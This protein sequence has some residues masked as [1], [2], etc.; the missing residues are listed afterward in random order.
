MG[1][2]YSSTDSQNLITSMRTNL[3]LANQ[4]TDRLSSGCDHLIATLE[5]GELKGAAYTAGKGLFTEVIIPAIKK[6]QDAIDDIQAEL[7][8]YEY[9]DS[10][11]AEYGIL[12][13]DNLEQQLELKYEQLS[14]V[15]DQ[16][17]INTK[18]STQ[19]SALF[20]G[21]IGELWSQNL[22]LDELKAQI[23]MGIDD[24]K[25]RIEKLNWFNTD[26]SKYFSDSLTVL[27]L[28]IQGALALS[29]ITMDEHGNYY[30]NG[31][32]MSWLNSMTETVLFT[33]DRG[34]DPK[35]S[36]INDYARDLMLSDEA[37]A[38]YR[39]QLTTLLDGQPATE[40]P[41]IIAAYNQTLLF[42]DQGSLLTIIPIN[43]GAGDGYI[44][45]KNGDYDKVYTAQVNQ[46][47]NA[48]ML[49]NLGDQLGQLLLGLG[50][51]I[52]GIGLGAAS[53]ALGA[54]GLV[55]ALPTGGIVT[56]PI[57]AVAGA[58]LAVSGTLVVGGVATTVDSLIQLR[59][60]N[61]NLQ[62][63]FAK[64]YDERPVSRTFKKG[65]SGRVNGRKVD[66]IR[67]D[68]EWKSG[69]S[70]KIQ[71]QSGSGKRGYDLNIDI[72]VSKI[73]TQQDII[74]WVTNHPKLK[75][76]KPGELQQVIDGMWRAYQSIPK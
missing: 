42:D 53:S 58:G 4:I 62:I 73:K 30:S 9:A 41:F 24:V 47:V 25:E 56:I 67:V 21:E 65:I 14:I 61:A 54:G 15:E 37:T 35:V 72:D 48:Q 39:K 34:T 12:D 60:A 49:Q 44:V 1:L 17:E 45:L 16:L 31:S 22:A 76:L 5:S 2:K 26:V 70:G 10:I 74:D 75:G 64:G 13:L 38:Y 33:T 68:A 55:L 29:N 50:E 6:L 57:E 52:G 3:I 18:L 66:N 43:V 20:S 51:I 59:A 36:L 69:T 71:V 63:S 40:W 27:Q 19:A 46:E 7:T 28:A 8:S 11:V 32:D 23:Q